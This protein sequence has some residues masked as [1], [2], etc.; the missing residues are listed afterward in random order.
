MRNAG[1]ARLKL[2]AFLMKE[3]MVAYTISMLNIATS[4]IPISSCGVARVPKALL[5]MSAI[6]AENGK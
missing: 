2:I 5:S 1:R 6:G 3:R 4:A